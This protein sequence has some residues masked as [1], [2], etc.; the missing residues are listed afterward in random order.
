M[1]PTRVLPQDKRLT[2]T[3]SERVETN[4][5]CKWTEKE[6]GVTILKSDNID[7]KETTIKRYL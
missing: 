2:Q 6:A 1:L 5:P 3:E 4:F 7:F